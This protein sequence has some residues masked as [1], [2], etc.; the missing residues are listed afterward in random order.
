MLFRQISFPIHL[1]LCHICSYTKKKLPSMC[2]PATA[3]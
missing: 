3:Q 1:R 2:P